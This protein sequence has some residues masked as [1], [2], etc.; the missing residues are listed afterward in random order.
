[1]PVW[2]SR[3]AFVLFSVLLASCAGGVVVGAA[4][5]ETR[6]TELVATC[7]SC[8]ERW[9]YSPTAT[10]AAGFAALFN[11]KRK[12]VDC[13]P[14]CASRVVKFGHG[15]T[16]AVTARLRKSGYRGSRRPA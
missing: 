10:L 15:A 14:K 8:G 6:V 5:A 1:M 9:L 4:A 16:A 12:P 2:L 3:L 7:L 11:R 13:C